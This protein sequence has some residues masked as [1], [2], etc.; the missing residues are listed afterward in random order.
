[1]IVDLE[2]VD[3]MVMQNMDL[4]VKQGVQDDD[5]H[6]EIDELYGQLGIHRTFPTAHAYIYG[7]TG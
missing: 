2:Y 7:I 4:R 3:L 6:G 5:E 1:M